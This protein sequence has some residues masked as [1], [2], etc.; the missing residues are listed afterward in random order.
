MNNKKF[1]LM[2]HCH[3]ETRP[4]SKASGPY[5]DLNFIYRTYQNLWEAYPRTRGDWHYEIEECD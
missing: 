3:K 2:A 4:P 5:D 1:N